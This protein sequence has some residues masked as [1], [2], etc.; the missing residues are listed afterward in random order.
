MFVIEFCASIS[1]VHTLLIGW[2]GRD[3]DT[4]NKLGTKTRRKTKIER[5]KEGSKTVSFVA[6]ELV[7]R[8]KVQMLTVTVWEFQSLVVPCTHQCLASSLQNR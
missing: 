2:G 1:D 7:S 5:E 3:Y 4:Y 6:V 8:S